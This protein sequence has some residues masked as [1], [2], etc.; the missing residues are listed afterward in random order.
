[1]GEKGTVELK[2][3]DYFKVQKYEKYMINRFLFIVV[4]YKISENAQMANNQ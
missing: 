4:R 3:V 1:M 2:F